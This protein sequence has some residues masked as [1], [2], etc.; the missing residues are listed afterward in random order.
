M[1]LREIP[2]MQKFIS[3]SNGALDP[4]QV[5]LIVLMSIFRFDITWTIIKAGRKKISRT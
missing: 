2:R 3:R 5:T 1:I 4:S